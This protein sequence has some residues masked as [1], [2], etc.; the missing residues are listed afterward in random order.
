MP[1]PSTSTPLKVEVASPDPAVSVAAPVLVAITPVLRVD[2]RAPT[3]V[4]WSFMSSVPAL[5]R[6]AAVG[7]TEGPAAPNC[8]VP[9]ST[10]VP[11]P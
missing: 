8:S 3:V 6:Q 2:C 9:A 11:P 10:D 5:T 7:G 1:P 4:V